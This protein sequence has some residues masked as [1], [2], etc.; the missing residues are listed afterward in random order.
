MLQCSNTVGVRAGA[1]AE[2][3]AGV[4]V[5][6]G[7]GVGVGVGVRGRGSSSSSLFFDLNLL[8]RRLFKRMIASVVVTTEEKLWRIAVLCKTKRCP[9]ASVLRR[10]VFIGFLFL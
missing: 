5:G 7:G 3:V 6:V 10:N 2:V 9:A 4:G 8:S 1:G